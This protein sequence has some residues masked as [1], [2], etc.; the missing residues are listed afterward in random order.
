VTPVACGEDPSDRRRAA[1][2]RL[3]NARSGGGSFPVR[4][5]SSWHVVWIHY[6]NCV[7][8]N[9]S[10]AGPGDVSPCSLMF[11]AVNFASLNFTA[12]S[13]SVVRGHAVEFAGR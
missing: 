2:S 13:G 9:L 12:L 1:L 6:A 5:S 3:T 10:S 7:E 11:N 4:Q 8:G